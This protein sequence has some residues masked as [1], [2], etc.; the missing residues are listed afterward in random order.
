[1][2][3]FGIIFLFLGSSLG[4][5]LFTMNSQFSPGVSVTPVFMANELY[6]GYPNGFGGQPPI[7]GYRIPSL[8]IL[9]DNTILAF[10]EARENPWNDMGNND[11]VMR[12]SYDGGTTWS[13]MKVLVDDGTNTVGNPCGVYDKTTGIIHML[14]NINNEQIFEITS[15]DE[16]LTWS[17]PEISPVH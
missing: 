11:S 6:N 17:T 9:P 2:V 14:F 13:D 3:A 10:A 4:I 16:G 7:K 5:A 15:A 8:L 1:M 12:I